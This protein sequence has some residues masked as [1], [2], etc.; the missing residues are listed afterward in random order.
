MSGVETL[1]SKRRAL[2][3]RDL[4]DFVAVVLSRPHLDVDT[5]GFGLRL[6][7]LAST[8]GRDN[9]CFLTAPLWRAS[10]R[11]R[12]GPASSLS[13]GT[14][15]RTP[16][17][18]LGR[19]RR[20]L[21]STPSFPK[22]LDLFWAF[23]GRGCCEPAGLSVDVPCETLGSS[24]PD[25]GCDFERSIASGDRDASRLLGASSKLLASLSKLRGLPVGDVT[26]SDSGRGDEAMAPVGVTTSCH[27]DYET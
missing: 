21:A 23:P 26:T 18:E 19:E 27:T 12:C 17:A 2:L 16:C 4:C 25:I 8:P 5:T 22:L 10:G 9:V 3:G 7:P 20:G 14:L 15:P 24:G 6:G 13:F 11:E 1:C